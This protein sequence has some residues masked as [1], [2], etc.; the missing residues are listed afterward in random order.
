L[1]IGKIGAAAAAQ[2]I[3]VAALANLTFKLGLVW[4]IAGRELFRPVA[5]GFTMI[6]AG[7]GLGMALGPVNF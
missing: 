3:L 2:S 6:A 1:G 7:I 4:F 5:L